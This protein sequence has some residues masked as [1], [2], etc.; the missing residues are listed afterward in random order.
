MGLR[1]PPARIP[2]V[3]RRIT[4]SI[5]TRPDRSLPLT[6][7]VVSVG[8]FDGVHLGHAAIASR[9]SGVARS[10]RLPALAVTFDPHPATILRPGAAP[11][12][13]TTINRRAALLLDQGFDAVAVLAANEELMSLDPEAFYA[14]VLRGELAARGIVEG[15]DFRFGAGRHGDIAFLRRRGM[16]DG[17]LVEAVDPVIADGA[18]VSSSRIRKL[19]A[20]GN[21]RSAARLL[22]APYR[23]RGLV[24][25]GRQRGG[26]IGFPTA[27]LDAIETLVPA[28]GVYAGRAHLEDGNSFAAAIHIG[29][30]ATFGGTASVVE[31][32]LIGFAGVLYEKWLDVDFLERL[33]ETQVFDTIES[34][35]LQLGRD[36]AKAEAVNAEIGRMGSL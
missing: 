34:L 32:H 21:V 2:A 22:T 36:V 8:N 31:V 33:R 29:P 14:E 11:Q 6:A 18:P 26:P 20:E 27:N 25:P 23:L 12:P 30:T 3:P 16:D 1:R 9:T 17:L 24:V 35:R 15:S 28:G 13:L 4:F 5:R 7:A 19:L 10:L